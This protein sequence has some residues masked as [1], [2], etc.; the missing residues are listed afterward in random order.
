MGLDSSHLT[1]AGSPSLPGVEFHEIKQEPSKSTMEVSIDGHPHA[2]A[3]YH[4]TNFDPSTQLES[5][6]KKIVSLVRDNPARTNPLEFKL[7]NGEV[8]FKDRK[9]TE[10]PQKIGTFTKLKNYI[11]NWISSFITS[12]KTPT[13]TLSKVETIPVTPQNESPKL[14]EF[15]ALEAKQALDLIHTL[16]DAQQAGET[17]V[18]HNG[19]EYQ[20]PEQDKYGI[21]TW[22]LDINGKSFEIN[23]FAPGAYHDVKTEGFLKRQELVMD[24]AELYLTEMS[25]THDYT[26]GKNKERKESPDPV[27]TAEQ[28]Q[29]IMDRIKHLETKC[30]ESIEAECQIDPNKIRSPEGDE[31]YK[32]IHKIAE[33]KIAQ[34]ATDIS[35]VIKT[36]IPSGTNRPAFSLKQL[37]EYEKKSVLNRG[38]PTII[39][40]FYIDSKQFVSMQIPVSKTT[41]P[42]TIRNSPGL[43]NY[44]RTSFGILDENHHMQVLYSGIRHSSY[45]P[46]TIADAYK[47]QAIAGQNARQG[48]IDAAQNILQDTDIETSPEKPLEVPLRSMLLLTAKQIDFVRNRSYGIIGKWKGESETTQLEESAQALRL[49]NNRVIKVEIDGKDVW[50]KPNISFMNLGANAAATNASRVSKLADAA[51]QAGINARGFNTLEQDISKWTST[52]LDKLKGQVSP[53]ILSLLKNIASDNVSDV[54]IQKQQDLEASLQKNLSILYEN[55]E[56]AQDAYLKT[57]T[58]FSKNVIN[59]TQEEIRSLEK[60]IDQANKSLLTARTKAFRK[61]ESTLEQNVNILKGIGKDPDWSA[62]TTAQFK[63]LQQVLAL[64]YEAQKVFHHK[65]FRETD[66]VMDFQ[67]AYNLLQDKIGNI[68]EFFCKSA[69]DRTGR[70][71]DRMQESLVFQALHGRFP[72]S[73]DAE[74]VQTYAVAI[75]QYSASQNNTEQNSNARG[76]QIGTEIN[77]GIPARRGKLHSVLAKHIF[78]IAKK[79]KP[80]NE[81]LIS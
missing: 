74:K 3:L 21:T 26:V 51:S 29:E 42:S 45:P 76:E 70:V 54:E 19:T 65:K 5:T 7:E 64:H 32:Q 38:R 56:T 41:I 79:L 28:K 17:K 20:I 15:S 46:I 47:R 75:N 25:T 72:G 52:A 58:S 77:K 11:S 61:R 80:S 78:K 53:E 35:Y 66:H 50:I 37:A 57:G 49:F 34:L 60:Q 18:I 6:L 14:K 33:E 23:E 16:R 8:D 71:D 59:K 48:L 12:K 24:A 27:I 39:N 67:V 13:P 1:P 44:V 4:D 40:T 73:L 9:I 22:K 10:H 68:N 62:E 43:V 55:L 81:A 2:I 36:S 69:E 30:K 31:H 63:D